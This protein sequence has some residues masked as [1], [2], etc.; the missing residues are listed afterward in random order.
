VRLNKA[1]QSYYGV[2]GQLYLRRLVDEL[3]TNRSALEAFLDKETRTFE[4]NVANDPQVDPRIRRRFAG[5]YAAGQLGLRYKILPPECD[6]FMDA[7]AS[8]YW[9]AIDLDSNSSLSAAEAAA[10]V[11]KFLDAN[12]GRLLKV[13]GDGAI[14]ER[15]FKKAIGLIPNP[16]HHDGKVWLKSKVLQKSVFSPGTFESVVKKLGD[17]DV[18]VLSSSGLASRQQRV[19]GLDIREYFYVIDAEK[20][21]TLN[22]AQGSS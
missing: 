18:I 1:C 4:D 2:A 20:L 15:S 5:L 11:A 13:R 3:A 19:P 14:T 12:A 17:S 7:I 6:W 22:R 21:R 9:A 8:C 16:D 10:H